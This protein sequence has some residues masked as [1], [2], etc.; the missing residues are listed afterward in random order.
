[1]LV[2][3]F[4]FLSLAG[5]VLLLAPWAAEGEGHLTFSEAAF[6]AVSAVCVTGLTVID[7]SRELSVAGEVILVVLVQL[8]GLGIM[9]FSTAAFRMIGRRMG[10]RHEAA[11]AGL[12]SSE[13]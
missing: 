10:L 5:T 9:T 1:L 4:A 3:T 11:V 2:S 8:G 6:T 13:D 12:V 7:A